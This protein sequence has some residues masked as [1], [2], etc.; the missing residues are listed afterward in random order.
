MM[1]RPAPTAK[2]LAVR[3]AGDV[4]APINAVASADAEAGRRIEKH[5]AN[6]ASAIA[7]TCVM[8]P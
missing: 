6:A 2:P 8:T 4:V 3:F 5:R 1:S 7:R